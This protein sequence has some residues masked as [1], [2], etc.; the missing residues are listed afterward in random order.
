[1]HRWDKVCRNAILTVT[2]L[3]QLWQPPAS[4]SFYDFRVNKYIVV[5]EN[6]ETH[7]RSYQN[8]GTKKEKVIK[9]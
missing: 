4:F 1:M 9:I 3:S 6:I 7:C 2:S 8:I 5:M